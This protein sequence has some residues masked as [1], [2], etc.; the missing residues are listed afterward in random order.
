MDPST[1]LNRLVLAANSVADDLGFV[2]LAELAKVL[3][4]H[5]DISGTRIIGGHMVMLHVQ[6]WGLGR[7]LYRETQDADL[8]VA[9]VVVKDGAIISSLLDAGYERAAGNR[10]VRNV[11]D[12]P[13]VLKGDGEQP[14]TQAAIDILTPAY[15]SRARDNV[16]ISDD[17]TTTEVLGLALALKRPGIELE[18]TLQRINGETLDVRLVIPDEVSA[19]VLKVLA[20]KRRSAPK[21][22][23]DIWRMLEV[24]LAAGLE[25]R[26]FEDAWSGADEVLT[27][28]FSS[29]DGPAMKAFA[30]AGSLS[31]EMRRERHTRIRALIQRFLST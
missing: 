27:D 25:P 28:D 13:L 31:E 26:H 19:L 6:R 12:I 22:A 14:K 3:S 15:R 29:L 30:A 8:G 9:P 21:D 16:K 11:R 1:S 18:L 5:G 17:L 10:F 23:V 7:E 24:S 20:W 2:A 4:S